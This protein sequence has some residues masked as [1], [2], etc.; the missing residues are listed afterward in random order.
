[1]LGVDLRVI[2]TTGQDL[3]TLKWAPQSSMYLR[4]IRMSHLVRDTG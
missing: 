4:K 1:M 2:T 3:G